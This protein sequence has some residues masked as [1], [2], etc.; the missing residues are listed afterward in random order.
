MWGEN[1]LI[2]AFFIGNPIKYTAIYSNFIANKIWV[3]EWMGKRVHG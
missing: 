1:K 2:L 3:L